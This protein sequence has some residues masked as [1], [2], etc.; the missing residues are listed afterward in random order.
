MEKHSFKFIDFKGAPL[1]KQFFFKIIVSGANKRW[2]NYFINVS[3]TFMISWDSKYPFSCNIKYCKKLFFTETFNNKKRNNT[4]LAF[5]Y[6]SHGII[7][8]LCKCVYQVK[9]FSRLRDVAQEFVFALFLMQALRYQNI[10]LEK[11]VCTFLNLEILKNYNVLNYELSF[12]FDRKQ[13][14]DSI[15]KY[16]FVWFF[17]NINIFNILFL[18]SNIA[19]YIQY[20]Y[21][22]CKNF[23]TKSSVSF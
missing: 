14:T 15:F 21:N 9:L 1:W 20:N 18:L 2:E 7:K 16:M 11:C 19:Y 5:S 3:V 4:F 10:Y 17:F 8:A 23:S 22:F 13:S 12:C 6:E